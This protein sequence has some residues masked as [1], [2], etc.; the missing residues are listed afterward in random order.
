MLLKFVV[1]MRVCMLVHACSGAY[2][3]VHMLIA[4]VY[5]CVEARDELTDH[6]Q[7][8]FTLLFEAV[9]PMGLADEP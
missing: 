7:E 2:M 4:H 3:P 1:F 5:T 9:S 8:L 6:S